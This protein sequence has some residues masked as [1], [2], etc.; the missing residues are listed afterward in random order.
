MAHFLPVWALRVGPPEQP[1]FREPR[2]LPRS[3]PVLRPQGPSALPVLAMCVHALTSSVSS[4]TFLYSCG[5]RPRVCVSMRLSPVHV[6][7]GDAVACMQARS[8]PWGL[9]EVAKARQ[10]DSRPLSVVGAGVLRNHQAV[11]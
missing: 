4:I 9:R 10:A 2:P 1:R 11:S 7:R 6:A 5:F 8:W 3:Q